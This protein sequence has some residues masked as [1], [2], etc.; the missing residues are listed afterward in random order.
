MQHLPGF[1]TANIHLEHRPHPR[2]E[3]RAVGQRRGVRGHASQ[4]RTPRC[5]CGQRPNRGQLRT[6]ACTPSN[7]CTAR[8]S[9]TAGPG[10]GRRPRRSTASRRRGWPD[11]SSTA[12]STRAA[13]ASS[14]TWASSSATDM[15]AAVGSA[16]PWPAM[17]G[18][19]PCT[20]SNIDGLVRVGVDVAA[21]G[22]P[23]AAADRGGQVGDDVAEQVVGDDHVEAARVGDHVDG[24]GVDVLVGDLDVGEL[25]ADL[26]HDP[27]PQAARRRSARWSCAPASGACAAAC[28]RANASR[29]TR[30][31]AERGV[32]ADLGGDL[33]RRAH[34][35]RA[36]V[37]GVRALGALAHDDEVDVRRRRPAGC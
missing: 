24:G 16:M 11:A 35:E 28:A 23:D 6:C 8:L 5:T 32:D 29:T 3:L 4:T 18:A 25:R 30:S 1:R 7:R 10:S 34:P 2:R 14:P 12:L 26:G 17:S 37:A 9:V 27:R 13:A 20:G 22:Q 15:T 19:L 33:V 21:G 31:H 36:A